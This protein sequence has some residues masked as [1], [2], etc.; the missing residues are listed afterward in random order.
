MS[1]S[2]SLQASQYAELLRISEIADSAD[3]LRLHVTGWAAEQGLKCSFDPAK[4]PH[5]KST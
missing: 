2:P 5:A 3:E 4:E 1:F